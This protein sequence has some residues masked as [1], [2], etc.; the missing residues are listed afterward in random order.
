LQQAGYIGNYVKEFSTDAIAR[1]GALHGRTDDLPYREFLRKCDEHGPWVW[2]DP[3]LWLT[4]YFWKNLLNMQECRFILLTRDLLQ[5]WVSGTLRRNVRNYG[6]FKHYET[7]IVNSIISFLKGNNLP[8]L[9]IT[10]DNL[11]SRPE[12]TI[13][14]LNRH[15]QAH[16]TIQDL[17]AVYKGSLHRSPRKSMIDCARAGLIYLKSRIF[18]RT[19]DS[20]REH[21]P[22]TVR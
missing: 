12:E 19:N 3:R 13:S 20:E 6:T 11:I 9:H 16:L 1:V 2:K 21:R 18:D 8:Y 10:Y 5:G 17:E 4:I 22:G 14:D 15:L 7:S